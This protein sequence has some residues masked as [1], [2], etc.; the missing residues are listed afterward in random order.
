MISSG[1]IK[2]KFFRFA[3]IIHLRIFGHEMDVEMRLFLNSLSWSFFGSIF[4]GA[5][6][7]FVNVVAGR[8]L[9]PYDYGV[10][11]SVLSLGVVFSVLF[12]LG[13]DLSSVRFLSD[14]RNKPNFSRI[15]T[16][17]TVIV[18]FLGVFIS[19]AAFFFNENVFHYDNLFWVLLVA[20]VVSFKN[21]FSGFLR[22]FEM[23]KRQSLFKLFDASLVFLLFF[24]LSFFLFENTTYTTYLM[25]TIIGG[26][27]FVFLAFISLRKKFSFAKLSFTGSGSD[28]FSYSKF[29][30]LIYLLAMG[31]FIDKYLI[32]EYIGMKE[33]GYFSA[34]YV[35]THLV[36]S[37]L[38]STFMNVFWPSVIKNA[39]SIAGILGKIDKLFL[40][41]SVPF[42]TFIF[43]VASVFIL[44]FGSEY[45][46]D[47]SLVLLFSLSTFF[48]V[49]YSV[50][51][52]FMNINNIK[53]SVVI[54]FFLYFSY[55]LSILFFRSIEVYLLTQ[56][57]LQAVAV[58]YIRRFFIKTLCVV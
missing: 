10:Y 58:I 42:F 56:V 6:L 14:P 41:F 36:I 46:F 30:L 32:G 47:L 26:S 35:A 7:F 45:P 15:I 48:G 21:L 29:S 52:S 37:E 18:L 40:Y 54:S 28:F 57:I 31:S 25:S 44:L 49:L 20:F 8:V 13:I 9:G 38:F 34:Y 55:P 12:L 5:I 23:I 39:G 51:I 50:F 17:S 4:A 1:T 24:L 27:L 22:S 53:T 33:L 2:Q 16:N 19:I 3:E 43:S 11:N